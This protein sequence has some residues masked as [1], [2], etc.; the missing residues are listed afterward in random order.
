MTITTKNCK[1]FIVNISSFIGEDS[2]DKWNRIK[3]YNIEPYI[4]RDFKNSVGRIL[5]IA[6]YN[7]ELFLYTLG[8]VVSISKEVSDLPEVETIG[9][10]YVGHKATKED[11]KIFISSCIKNNSSIVYDDAYTDAINP[12]KWELNWDFIPLDE[13]DYE[14]KENYLYYSIDNKYIKN[15]NIYKRENIDQFACYVDRADLYKI[16]CL[17]MPDYDTAYRI[18]IYETNDHYLHLGLNNS[19]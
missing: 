17:F 2:N 14:I 3:K 12:S 1:D 8:E 11:L 6:Q 5:T 4:L 16:H 15:R 7:N 9:M 13:E 19:D 10:H 18:S